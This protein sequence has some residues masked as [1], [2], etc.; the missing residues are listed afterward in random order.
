M[1]L[2]AEALARLQQAG[3]PRY[4]GMSHSELMML[5]N[6]YPGT[7]N[8]QNVLAPYEHRAFAREQAQNKP[9]STAITMPFL[10]PGYTAAKALGLHGA[11]S[12]PSL[13]Q[14]KQGYTGLA[15][16]LLSLMK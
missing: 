3:D 8:M 16:G 11:R 1:S 6:Q 2:L 4:A 12:E 10:I 5:R 13:D 15:E 7:S 14:I 9:I